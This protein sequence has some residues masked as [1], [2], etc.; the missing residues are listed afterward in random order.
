MIQLEMYGYGRLI[1]RHQLILPP[2]LI[3][4]AMGNTL[5]AQLLPFILENNIP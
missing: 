3:Y 2:Q 4:Q 1:H 5:K